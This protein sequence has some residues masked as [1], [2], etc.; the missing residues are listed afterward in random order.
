MEEHSYGEQYS[1]GDEQSEEEGMD[2]K[3][4]WM[5]QWTA[6][7]ELLAD[8]AHLRAPWE[9]G[10]DFTLTRPVFL[11]LAGIVVVGY[12]YS[13]SQFGKR[14]KHVDFELPIAGKVHHI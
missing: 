4:P 8:Y 3:F 14:P 1:V 12:K 13:Q 6:E 7:E 9:V 5:S 10:V 11:L 2:D